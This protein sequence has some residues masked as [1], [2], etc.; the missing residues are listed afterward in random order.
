[1]R[2]ECFT[3]GAKLVIIP[4]VFVNPP[5]KVTVPTHWL[6][7][8]GNIVRPQKRCQDL[9]GAERVRRGG[10]KD[11]HGTPGP[12]GILLDLLERDIVSLRRQQHR[13]CTR[14]HTHTHRQ[15]D[16]QADRQTEVQTYTQ[17]QTDRQKCRHTQTQT[18][19]QT[20]THT[21]TDRQT[22]RQI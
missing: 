15:T 5:R 7:L 17:R 22:D 14:A 6:D 13:A 16:S 2:K 20:Y 18:E 4:D 11:N 1:M 21:Q 12:D 8:V 3:Y 19:V 10:H 9:A